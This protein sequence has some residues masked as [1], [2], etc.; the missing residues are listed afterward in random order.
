MK[1]TRRRNIPIQSLQKMA[2]IL[3]TIAHP[4]RLDILELLETKESLT[5]GE[6]KESLGQ[7]VETS[8]L[9]H[10]LI[11]MKDKGVLESQKQ[12]KFIYYKLRDQH[13]LQIFDCMEACKLIWE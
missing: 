4:V 1:S 5:V 10:H 7:P 3:K 2:Q 6:I 13:I 8:M 11:K 12:G 9:S